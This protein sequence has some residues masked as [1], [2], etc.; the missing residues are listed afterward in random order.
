MRPTSACQKPGDPRSALENLAFKCG[1]AATFPKFSQ[2]SANRTPLAVIPRAFRFYEMKKQICKVPR[3]IKSC[4][5]QLAFAGGI[6]SIVAFGHY[7]R[8][9][10]E[11]TWLQPLAILF[12]CFFFLIFLFTVLR[13]IDRKPLIMIS[14]GGIWLRRSRFPFSKL[15]FSPWED[16]SGY[17][18][19]YRTVKGSTSVVLKVALKSSVRQYRIELTALGSASGDV[20]QIFHSY[21]KKNVITKLDSVTY[22]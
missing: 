11:G 17:W 20:S 8:F 22:T 10:K 16:I 15:D 18:H 13:L 6:F 3:S 1:A 7:Q 19:E 21:A 4:I 2:P 9:K 14:D 12:D 5:W